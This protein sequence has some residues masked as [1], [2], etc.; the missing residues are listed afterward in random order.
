MIVFILN[1]QLIE[2]EKPSGMPLLDFIREELELT[3]TKIGCREGDCGACTLMEGELQGKEVVYKTIVS[4]LTPLGNVHG[5]HVVTIEG[6]SEDHLTPIQK[7]FVDHSATQCGFCTPGFIMSLTAHSLSKDTSDFE[8]TLAAIDGN[9]CRCTGYKSIERAAK[10]CWEYNQ[11]R[12]DENAV[13]WMVRN[14]HLPQWFISIPKRLISLTK[15]ETVNSEEHPILGGGTDLMVQKADELFNSKVKL[16]NEIAALKGISESKGICTIGGGETMTNIMQSELLKPYF[17]K[18]EKH[19]S[20]IASSPIRNSG[21]IAG[22]IVNASPIADLSI[23]FLALNAT[24]LLSDESGNHRKL[25][26]ND[27]FTGYKTLK[28][29]SSE[30]VLAIRFKLPGKSDYFNF[31]KVSKREHLDIATVNSAL[32]IRIT[33]GRIENVHL[34]AGGVAPIPLYLS[35]TCQFLKAKTP[36]RETLLKA[37]EIIQEEIAP[38]SDIRGSEKYKRLLLRQL[39]FAHFL[40]LFPNIVSADSLNLTQD[41]HEEH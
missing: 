10:S 25:P 12:K 21:T 4:C 14:N 8:K 32:S 38:I 7:A 23:F 28:M 31:E 36:D 6:I 29:E 15:T 34:S 5:K 27:F 40:E 26:L 18:L 2:T 3:G 35:S 20:L 16:T 37:N 39:F 19:F 13:V 22:N 33:D 41:N 17:P 1:K 9:I 30:Y 11:S 24:V